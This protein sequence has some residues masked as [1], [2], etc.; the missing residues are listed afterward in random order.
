M[1][2]QKGMKIRFYESDESRNLTG[3][4]VVRVSRH[5]V[6]VESSGGRR[7]IRKSLVVFA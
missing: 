2:F 4:T 3:G 5:F 1:E 6:T 7:L